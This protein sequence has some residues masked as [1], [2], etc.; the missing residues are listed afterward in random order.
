M[1]AGIVGQG[2]IGQ[3]GSGSIAQQGMDGHFMLAENL[4]D[5]VGHG[6][7][8]GLSGKTVQQG[9][10]WSGNEQGTVQPEHMDIIPEQHREIAAIETFIAP[11][12]MGVQA[13]GCGFLSD[14]VKGQQAV[15]CSEQVTDDE[16]EG[17]RHIGVEDVEIELRAGIV[18]HDGLDG[19][20]RGP[21]VFAIRAKNDGRLFQSRRWHGL[22]H[23][24][25]VKL[26]TKGLL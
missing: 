21:E 2:D 23:G 1:L 22:S 6:T 20:E 19:T 14:I 25:I 7:D 16:L 9:G 24:L 8:G 5:R 11:S 17:W 3:P 10:Q 12:L 26:D 13:Q 18:I 15:F 4:G